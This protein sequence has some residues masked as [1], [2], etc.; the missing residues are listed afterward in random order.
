MKTNNTPEISVIMLTYNREN[1][2]SNMVEC[3]LNQTFSMFEFIIVDNGSTDRSGIIADKYAESDNRIRVIHKEN[4][5]IGSG[6]NAGIDVA[7]GKYIAFVDDDDDC[8]KDFLE[9]LY[10]LIIETQADVS[11]CG[12]TWSNNEEK[13]VMSSEEAL[14]RLLW[15]KYYNVAFP[16]KLIRTDLLKNNRFNEYGKYDD[17]YLMPKILAY[18]KKIAY[19]GVSKYC[20]NRHENNNSA[21]TQH[22]ELLDN[23]TLVEYLNVYNERTLWLS[24]LFPNRIKIWNYFNYSFMISMVEKVSRYNINDCFATQNKM[25]KYLKDNS[26]EFCESKWITD[27]EKK[28]MIEYV[29]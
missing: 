17:I 4:G 13:L 23:D 25:I 24:N 2:I 3:I 16:T 5:T 10:N 19:C 28:W 15:R 11:I 1:M 27:E 14:E 8:D 21:W 12:A 29:L 9:F 6:R 20:F 26:A 22:H 18:A 7:A